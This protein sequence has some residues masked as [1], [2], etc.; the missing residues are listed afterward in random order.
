MIESFSIDD[1][2]KKN[3]EVVFVTFVFIYSAGCGRTGTICA[4]DYAWTLLKMQVS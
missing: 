4:V 1:D 2:K 3:D